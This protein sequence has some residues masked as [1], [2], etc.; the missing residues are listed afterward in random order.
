MKKLLFLLFPILF[1]AQ[2]P[3]VSSGKLIEYENF[4]SKY[5]GERMVRIW[6]PEDYN[7]LQKYQVLYANDGQMLWDATVTWNKQEWKLDETLAKLIKEKKIKPTI[8]VAIDNAGKNRHSEYFPQK[9][10]E[11]LN[12]KTQDSLY[13]LGKKETPLFAS[14][15]SSDNY[16]NFLGKELKPFVDAHYS[17]FTDAKHTFI[18]G[19][20][21]GG[22]ISMYAETEY[23]EVFGGAICM[24]THWPGVF[25]AEKN[26]VPGAFQD[27]LKQNLLISG[28]NKYYFD[29]GT[30]TLDAL[31]EPFQMKV[32]KVF[33]DK[34]Y[35]KRNWQTLKFPGENH[36]EIS[37]AKRLAIPLVFMLK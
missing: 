21:M 28:K 24:S 37:W 35:K 1:F 8:V 34:K 7:S 12:K 9:P 20:S 25:N 30:E 36:S 18:M 17:T 26:H 2:T 29:F 4:K 15:I 27:Y 32:D 22:L 23:P 31:Y 19:S 6:L 3:K 13:H 5:I 33:R 16:L 11:S 14:K 10:F